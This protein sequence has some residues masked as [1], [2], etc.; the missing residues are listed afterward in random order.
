MKF[1]FQVYS[2]RCIDNDVSYD[3]IFLRHAFEML[4]IL[5]TAMARQ[6]GRKCVYAEIM[7]KTDDDNA[8]V[9]DL[10]KEACGEK[11]ANCLEVWLRSWY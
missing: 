9:F 8:R 6:S 1:L 7:K 10:V 4:Q 2:E 5:C 11:R 3:R